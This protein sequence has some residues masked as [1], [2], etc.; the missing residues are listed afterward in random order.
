MVFIVSIDTITEYLIFLS[1]IKLGSLV[2]YV[3]SK[4]FWFQAKFEFFYGRPS[5]TTYQLEASCSKEV[6]N[7][8]V[9]VAFVRLT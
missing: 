3:T 8:L 6:S 5:R 1:T 9:S 4:F 7:V 2:Y